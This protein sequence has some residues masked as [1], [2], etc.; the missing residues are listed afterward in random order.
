M[1]SYP[2][3]R[4]SS[5]RDGK[6]PWIGVAG[7]QLP[8]G[9]G[10]S[11]TPPERLQPGSYPPPVPILNQDVDGN[12]NSTDDVD[13]ESTLATCRAVLNNGPPMRGNRHLFS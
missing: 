1:I 5:A 10:L 11:H 9:I 8:F 13:L 12:G 6:D 4:P 2:R 3:A 7:E